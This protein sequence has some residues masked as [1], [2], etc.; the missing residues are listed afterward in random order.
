[1]KEKLIQFTLKPDLVEKLE[2]GKQETGIK[3]TSDYMRFLIAANA[4]R[5]TMNAKRFALASA[6]SGITSLDDE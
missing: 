3:S 5:H 4:Y 2:V 1:M 6:Q